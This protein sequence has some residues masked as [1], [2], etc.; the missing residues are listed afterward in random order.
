LNAL[1]AKRSLLA[2][3]RPPP[4]A[5]CWASV[6]VLFVCASLARADN[7]DGVPVGVEAAQSGG[8]I[9]ATITAGASGFYNPAGVA[10]GSN[11]SIDISRPAA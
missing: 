10:G 9:T 1:T 11:D 2:L 6:L 5:V 7:D 4:L 8:A 3:R